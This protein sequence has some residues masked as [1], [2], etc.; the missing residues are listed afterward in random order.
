MYPSRVPGGKSQARAA[1][2]PGATTPGPPVERA[3]IDPARLKSAGQSEKCHI[4]S[5]NYGGGRPV[6]AYQAAA[7]PLAALKMMPPIRKSH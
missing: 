1:R 5:R 6:M 3:N 4:D 7:A 2:R